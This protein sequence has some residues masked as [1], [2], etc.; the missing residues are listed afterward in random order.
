MTLVS[1]GEQS[2]RGTQRPKLRMKGKNLAR[3]R[4]GILI[5]QNLQTNSDRRQV[6]RESK[7]WALGRD[8]QVRT[9]RFEGLDTV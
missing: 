2:L 3:E 5:P 6:L 4:K 7:W 1:E 8:L 9:G